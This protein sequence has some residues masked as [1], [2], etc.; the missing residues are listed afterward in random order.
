LLFY[1]VSGNPNSMG[2]P[3]TYPWYLVTEILYLKDIQKR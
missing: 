1:S 3:V 2:W